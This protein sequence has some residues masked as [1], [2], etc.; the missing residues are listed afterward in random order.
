M[1]YDLIIIG[2]GAAGCSA[3]L[4]ARQRNLK[5][6]VLYAGDGAMEKAHRMDNYPGMPMVEGHE[7]VRVFRQQAQD[8]G[9]ELKRQLVTKVLPMGGSFSVLAANDI[10]EGRSILLAM[11]TSRVNPLPGE[12]ELLGQGV[13]YCATCDGMFYRGKQIIVVAGGKEAV[14]D[15]NYLAD[16]AQVQYF[17]EKPH[18]TEELSAAIQV[19]Q[20]KPRGI[21]QQG[22]R[23]VLISDQ[24]E[25]EADGIFVIRPAVAMT[26]LLPEVESLK[27]RL[28]VDAELMTNVPGVFAA[29]DILGAPLQVA[30]AVGDGNRAALSIASFLRKTAGAKA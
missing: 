28:S 24:G 21:R 19:I 10:Y 13:S 15:A 30:K 11:G 29:G 22:E 23:L 25:H 16:L 18:D 9:A 1:S 5:T 20:E 8:L 3:A 14:E 2:G 7:M 12:E 6:L 17:T 27:G 26:Q 4:T